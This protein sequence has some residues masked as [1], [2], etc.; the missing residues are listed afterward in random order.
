MIIISICAKVYQ[1]E[2]ATAQKKLCLDLCANAD[3][4]MYWLA[5]AV[6]PPKLAL[7]LS[8][9]MHVSRITSTSSA[10]LYIGCPDELN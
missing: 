2:Q 1:N 9:S 3:P 7:L 5:Q 8:S 4:S 6:C 10:I